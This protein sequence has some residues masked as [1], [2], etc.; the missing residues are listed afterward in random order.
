MGTHRSI[1]AEPFEAL[2]CWSKLGELV[3]LHLLN[4]QNTGETLKKV[5]N[6]IVFRVFLG[7]WFTSIFAN[8]LGIWN[9]ECT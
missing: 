1:Q 5:A 4:A 2:S 7:L 6:R 8:Y 3:A 9:H